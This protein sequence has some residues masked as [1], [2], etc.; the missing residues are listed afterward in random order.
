MR[1]LFIVRDEFKHKN[2]LCKDMDELIDIYGKY[3]RW[4]SK[5]GIFPIESCL[6]KFTVYYIVYSQVKY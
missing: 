3:E 5:L 1:F 4:N 2:V 6:V